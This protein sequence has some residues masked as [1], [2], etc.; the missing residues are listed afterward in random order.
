MGTTATAIKREEER[1][2]GENRACDAGPVLHGGEVSK[3][4]RNAEF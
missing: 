3:G 1:R 2:G 4:I